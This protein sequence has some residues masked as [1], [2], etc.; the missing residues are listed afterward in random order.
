MPRLQAIDPQQASGQTKVILEAVDEKFGRVPN[1]LRTLANSPATLQAY[2]GFS[3]ALEGGVLPAKLREQIALAVSE[4]N[5]CGYCVSAHCAIGKSVG[6]SESELADARSSSS[7]DSKV[8]A[9]LHFARQVVDKRGWV[10]DEELAQVRRAGF[11]DSHITEILAVVAWK[12]LANYFNHV[13]QTEI[14]FP[15]VA[16]NSLQQLTP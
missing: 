7:P 3:E 1:L 4:A 16:T 5:G 12:T 10:T 2:V 13:A 11:D 8:E 15:E 14:D 6:L 9:A